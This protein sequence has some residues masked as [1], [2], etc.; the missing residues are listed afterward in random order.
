MTSKLSGNVEVNNDSNVTV[1]RRRRI[2]ESTPIPDMT[3]GI[4][5]G[6]AGRHRLSTELDR[7]KYIV[8]EIFIRIILSL[9]LIVL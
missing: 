5:G 3:V 2:T 9:L 4:T 7:I 8:V 1:R 6:S